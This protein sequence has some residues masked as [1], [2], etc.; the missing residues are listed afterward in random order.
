MKLRIRGDSIRIRVSQGELR[1]FAE[2]GQVRDTVHFGGGVGLTYAL[3]SDGQFAEA[4]KT[5][6]ELVG[7][8]DRISSAEF[9]VAAARCERRQGRDAE[10]LK[11]LQRA[12]A[13]FGETRY[14]QMARTEI[15][16]LKTKLGQ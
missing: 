4:G 7:R 5:Y 14:A 8:F 3:E 13:E 10:A 16:E 2:R 11:L 12:D 9:L 1:E 6:L 15:A